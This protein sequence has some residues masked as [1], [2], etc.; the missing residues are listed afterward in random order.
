MRK[1]ADM[2]T[3]GNAENA[4][5][6]RRRDRTQPRVEALRNPGWPVKKRLALKERNRSR[7]LAELSSSSDD[8]VGSSIDGRTDSFALSELIALVIG[9]QGSAKPPPWEP[10]GFE[11][12]AE[13]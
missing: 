11:G 13:R 6:R 2:G 4:R 9:T 10:V 12:G 5:K 1:L 3:H 7:D 8:N